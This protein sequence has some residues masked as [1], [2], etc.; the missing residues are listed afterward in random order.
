M[1]YSQRTLYRMYG[2]SSVITYK[3]YQSLNIGLLRNKNVISYFK[4]VHLEQPSKPV[5]KT[6]LV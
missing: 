3:D 1:I 2:S 6:F 4:V 5:G